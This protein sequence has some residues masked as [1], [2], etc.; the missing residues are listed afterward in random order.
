[1]PPFPKDKFQLIIRQTEEFVKQHCEHLDSAH[2]WDHVNRVRNLALRLYKQTFPNNNGESDDDVATRQ[3]LELIALLHDVGDFKFGYDQKALVTSFIRPL[4]RDLKVSG[5]L[6]EREAD[7]K[8][9]FILEEI[10]SVSWRKSLKSEKQSEDNNNSDSEQ[11]IDRISEVKVYEFVSD[12]DRLDAMGN[13]GIARC[14]AYGG[15]RHSKLYDLSVKPNTSLTKE[16]YDAQTEKLQDGKPALKQSK[17]NSLNHFYEKLLK[18]K[19][20]LKTEE[21]KKLAVVRHKRLVDF[22]DGFLQEV[23]GEV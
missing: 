16:S 4:F 11:Q 17:N 7:E 14:F 23:K 21:A 3:L 6:S 2:D 18:L 5:L 15:S 1:M 8:I 19:D 20:S 9:D 13:I 12:A 10:G 22:V